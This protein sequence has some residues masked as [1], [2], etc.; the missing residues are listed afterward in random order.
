MPFPPDSDIDLNFPIANSSWDGAGAGQFQPVKS[1]NEIDIWLKG[2][3]TY[4]RLSP[5]TT[6]APNSAALWPSFDDQKSHK[7]FSRALI[8]EAGE[9]DCGVIKATDITYA[10][11]TYDI[12]ILVA[13]KAIAC[14]AVIQTDLPAPGNTGQW[15]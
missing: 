8:Y 4:V 11:H 2:S 10:G 9:V 6:T 1:Q 3:K 12:V 15:R 14:G 13:S 5:G 7:I